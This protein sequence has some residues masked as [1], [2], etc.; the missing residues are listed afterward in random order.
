[1]ADSD[2]SP[3]STSLNTRRTGKQPEGTPASRSSL[4]PSHAGHDPPKPRLSHSSHAND[5]DKRQ[6]KAVHRSH[7][8]RSS[9]AFLLPDA[10]RPEPT[11][12]ERTHSHR[13]HRTAAEH[14]ITTTSGAPTPD[15]IQSNGT[16]NGSRALTPE[17][18]SRRSTRTSET[19]GGAA[20]AQ[21]D[22]LTDATTLD[23]S[24][25]SSAAPLDMDSAQIVNMA[26]NLSESRR[27]AARRNISTPLPP[28]LAPLPDTAAGG[29]LRQHLQQQRRASRN[30]SP[31]PGAVARSASG[32]NVASPL[33]PA[34]DQ[35]GSYRYQFSPST[36]SRAQKAKDYLE[37]QA[38]YRKVL[39]L[40]P[41]LTP[42]SAGPSS[43]VSP[44][45]SPMASHNISRTTTRSFDQHRLG[46]PYNP[47]Q[48][49][50]N[51]KVRA[52]ERKTIDGEVQGF[53]DVPRVSEWVDDAAKSVASGSI[54]ESG[55][56]LPT[57]N[58]PE[59]MA[60]EGTTPQPV[61][62][63]SKSKR[64]RVDWVIDPA[65]M[66][67]DVYWLE[68]GTN[69]NMVEDR[70]GK[71]VFDQDSSLYRPISRQMGDRSNLPAP[72]SLLQ[73]STGLRIETDPTGLEQKTSR[74]ENDHMFGSARERAQQKL[75]AIRGLHHRHNSSINHRHYDFL[76]SRNGSLS[77]S[78]DNDSDRKGRARGETIGSSGKEILEKQMLEMIARE[79]R[80]KE[81][82]A[83]LGSEAG[84][85]R[86]L[87]VESLAP[88]G[89]SV[90]HS[91]VPSRAPSL[92]GEQSAA[93][94][95][96]GDTITQKP[97]QLPVSPIRSTRAS[98]EVPSSGRRLSIDH[99]TSQPA[100]P[101]I[102]ATR[103]TGLI[104]AIG[105]DWS[106]RPSRP[107]SP[108]RNPLSKVKSI[109]R[110]RSRERNAYADE[111]RCNV[112]TNNP[113]VE[114]TP[115]TPKDKVRTRST[116]RRGSIS[117]IRKIISR[118]SDSSNRSPRNHGSLR[119][120]GDDSYGLRGLLKAP[121][122]D[123][124]LR[125]GVSR[126]SD[127]L[128]RKNL[129]AADADPSAS[130]DESDTEPGRGRTRESP[131]Q[132]DQPGT[133]TYLD[134]MPSFVSQSHSR[135][136]QG[137]DQGLLHP[138]HPPSRPLS[139]KSSR[140]ELLKPPKIDVQDTS[141]NALPPAQKVPSHTGSDTS[142]P[143]SRKSSTADAVRAA[144]SLNAAISVPQPRRLSTT[145]T[146]Q[147]QRHWSIS[148]NS[149]SAAAASHT[150]VSKPEIA[151]LR[152]L[153]LS[154][155]IMA[156]EI[157]RRARERRP[158]G[159]H[160]SRLLL[161]GGP[162]RRPSSTPSTTTTSSS[163]P[164][165][166]ILLA[167][168]STPTW[169]AISTLHPDPRVRASLLA[170]PLS[171][172]DL[173]PTAARTLAAAIEKA[174]TTWQS[175]TARF[176]TDTAPRLHRRVEGARQT[177]AGR[178]SDMTRAAGDEADEVGLD[179]SQG[180]RLKVKRVVDVIEKM[181]RRRRRRFRWVRRGL[182]LG[183]EWVLVGFMW[184]VWFVVVIARM[185]LGVGMG[186]VRGVRWLLWL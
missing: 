54:A 40:V 180:Q 102:R 38:Q 160:P 76:H 77:D 23:G 13:R 2:A 90:I 81:L 123:S 185:V 117:P 70:D 84:R 120:R 45:G 101:E 80:E 130:S 96:G 33:K 43:T 165:P 154:S 118:G 139:R 65:D 1:M 162:S 17:S 47:L 44:Y 151:R 153:I 52:R 172:T 113:T 155:G 51:R 178:L 48:Y 98:L 85:Q 32:H 176:E 106:P 121:R 19:I 63:V 95:N 134:V 42:Q 146:P 79:H 107:S 128:W 74:G 57:F 16:A 60:N 3:P 168:L 171:Q 115:E 161:P 97:K 125:S 91:T 8:H 182:W 82:E 175:A 159:S 72:S 145:T 21:R 127:L 4:T 69:K 53:S 110:D 108:S 131:A 50:R 137:G 6:S 39:D 116:E 112:A 140:F 119:L 100:S 181:L 78:S 92:R 104:P 114:P 136:P 164:S 61:V 64:P 49:I 9:G 58:T 94:A 122:I 103:G 111:R 109:F 124:V 157:D 166:T 138:A 24:E 31:R 89:D 144:D 169:T 30:I 170:Q 152:A 133:K 71:R 184:Y 28:R 135:P 29:S 5:D 149:R 179:L 55:S 167:P 36:L 59:E 158:P 126:V 25:R 173:F 174:G 46:R 150:V 62:T 156:K 183:V 142:G 93:E 73:D 12:P 68:Q 20:A 26:L 177:V 163:S 86:S 75:Q 22:S 148:D 141:P 14:H 186:V 143:D 41:P 37:L 99:D 129:D 66:L 7:K 18:A 88:E 11:V 147:A 10:L 87:T 34:F 27:L 132:P 15:K 35:E 56:T 83:R 67:A 105:K